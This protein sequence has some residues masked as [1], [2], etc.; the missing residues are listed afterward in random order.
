MLTLSTSSMLTD[1]QP[2]AVA[3]A[4]A[5]RA[6]SKTPRAAAARTAPTT[7]APMV[8]TDAA[9]PVFRTLL[10][11]SCGWPTDAAEPVARKRAAK[12]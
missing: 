11:P 9:R 6:R 3:P 2:D 1:V 4:P 7:P 10:V 8:S 12:R 5:K